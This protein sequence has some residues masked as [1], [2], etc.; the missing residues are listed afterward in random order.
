MGQW[1]CVRVVRMAQA[2]GVV[3]SGIDGTLAVFEERDDALDYA[4]SIAIT[5]LESILEGEDELG[6]LERRQA[7]STDTSGVIRCQP[8]PTAV[9]SLRSR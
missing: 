8:L 5:S 3:Q 1:S 4:R 7:L 6:Q 2:W 9:A